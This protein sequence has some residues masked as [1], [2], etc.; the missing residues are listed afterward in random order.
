MKESA[1]LKRKDGITSSPLP[2]WLTGWL[3][4]CF[5]ALGRAALCG[6]AIAL[7][8]SCSAI[9]GYPHDPGNSS[10]VLKSLQPY[11]EQSTEDAYFKEADSIKRRQLRDTIV[12]SRVRAYDLEYDNFEE[13][14]FASGSSFSIA[15]DLTVLVLTGLGATIG[16][17]T[18]KAALS[19]ASA[20]II[21]AQ[22]TISKDL[23]FQKTLPA[24]LAQ[25]EANRTKAELV[26][27]SG[28]TQ[29]DDR[30]P[31]LRANLDL[32]ALKKAGAIPAAIT[33]ITQQAA[34]STTA[35]QALI[36]SLRS[37]GMSS[38]SSSLRIRNWLY[39]G[40]K[41]HDAQG[42]LL[43]VDKT[44]FDAL[45]KWMHS[46]KIDPTLGSLP[47][48]VF[49]DSNAPGLE[50]ARQRALADKTLNIP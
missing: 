22:A 46:D 33:G 38:T 26:I 23:Y 9:Q 2:G 35:S 11:F 48:E 1:S 40:G 36:Q 13:S 17:A 45:Q 6:S 50:I 28:L 47:P 19:A 32:D 7:L 12:L 30:Y 21:G 27:F 16:E 14:L 18:T 37:S 42:K 29:D 24:L 4:G 41:D 43:P 31:L 34:D 3:T 49:I 15:S 44:K 8:A 5:R 25:M 10:A 20:G 39:P